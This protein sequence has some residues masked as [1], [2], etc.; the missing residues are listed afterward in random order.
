[1]R[2]NLPFLFFILSLWATAVFCWAGPAH[3]M[4]YTQRLFGVDEILPQAAVQEN[5]AWFNHCLA[6]RGADDYEIG[7]ACTLFLGGDLFPLTRWL[8]LACWRDVKD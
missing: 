4:P 1:M 5:V 7:V 2:L 3:P 8:I 6:I